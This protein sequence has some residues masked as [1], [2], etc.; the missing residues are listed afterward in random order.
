M[1]AD[2]RTRLGAMQNDALER[3]GSIERVDH[4]SLEAQREEAQQER[5]QLQ[6]RVRKLESV[7][8][9]YALQ[10]VEPD[11]LERMDAMLWQDIDRE[12]DTA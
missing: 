7:I 10:L 5:D 11:N 6:E 9:G 3:S 4:R 1:E 12:W 8:D 2:G